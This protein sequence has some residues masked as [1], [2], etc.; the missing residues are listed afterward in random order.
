M[1]ILTLI[2][3][4]DGTEC[5]NELSSWSRICQVH[6]SDSVAFMSSDGNVGKYGDTDGFVY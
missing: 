3:I 4:S 6:G 2:S 5:S 1:Q